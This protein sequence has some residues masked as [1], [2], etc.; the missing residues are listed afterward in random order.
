MNPAFRGLP[1]PQ[2]IYGI[3]MLK[4]QEKSCSIKCYTKQ[5]IET[6]DINEYEEGVVKEWLDKL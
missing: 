6:V 5:D 2:W 3:N 1:Y 4:K